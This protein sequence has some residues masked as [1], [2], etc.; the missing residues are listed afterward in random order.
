MSD[1]L[2]L[3]VSRPVGMVGERESVS[4]YEIVAPSWYLHVPQRSVLLGLL[5]QEGL[6][7][8]LGNREIL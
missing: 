1:W 4:V 6:Y 3:L 5:G 2:D 8:G 7:L